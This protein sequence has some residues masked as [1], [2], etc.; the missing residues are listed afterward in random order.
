[1]KIPE[2]PVDC[3]LAFKRTTT[4]RDLMGNVF[5]F[6][7]AEIFQAELVDVI[8]PEGVLEG[9]YEFRMWVDDRSVGDDHKTFVIAQSHVEIAVIP[10]PVAHNASMGTPLPGWKY[11]LYRG[12][13]LVRL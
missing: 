1:M 6:P 9:L 12:G 10:P 3:L 7:D 5:E 4:L 13:Q 11:T 2:L 8:P